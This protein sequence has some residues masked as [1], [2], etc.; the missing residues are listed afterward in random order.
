MSCKLKYTVEMEIIF[1]EI[2]PSPEF[3]EV[4]QPINDIMLIAPTPEIEASPLVQ[5]APS[6]EIEVAMPEFEAE[7][8]VLFTPVLE[9]E[10]EDDEQLEEGIHHQILPYTFESIYILQAKF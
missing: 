7:E 2:F 10:Y 1:E 3:E 8:L 5:F 6:P 4:V 9:P